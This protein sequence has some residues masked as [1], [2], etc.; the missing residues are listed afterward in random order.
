VVAVAIYV[1]DAKP[2][3]WVNFEQKLLAR[4]GPTDYEDFDEALSH[5]EQKGTVR[6]YQRE[7]ECLANRVVDWPEKALVGTFLGGLRANIANPVK[8]FKPWTLR[9]T[10]QFARMQD[11]QMK[12]AKPF[13]LEQTKE[14]PRDD[15]VQPTSIERSNVSLPPTNKLS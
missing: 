1:Q 15:S 14:A 6:E 13:L 10:I 12:R 8:M 3:V 2:L 11:D 4:F 7:F 9:E 5:I